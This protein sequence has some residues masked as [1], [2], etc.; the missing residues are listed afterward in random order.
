MCV[1]PATFAMAAGGAA[2][3]GQTAMGASGSIS[4]GYANSQAGMMRA[5][6]AQQNAKMAMTEA[7]AKISRIDDS[8]G[9]A[10]GQERAAF[11]SSN[12][13]IN[14]GSPLLMQAFSAAQGNMDKQ[15]AAA[16]GLNRAAGQNFAAADAARSADQSLRA[17]YLGAGTAL[18]SGVS[19]IAGLASFGAKSLPAGSG[20]VS[21]D[22]GDPLAYWQW[23]R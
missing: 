13:D 9:R 22:A 1:E 3:L 12:I 21:F 6:V 14:S 4:Q 20:S 19:R 2:A 5:M 10:I 7:S 17:G 11:G 16:E 15:L 8:V 23:G 18:L